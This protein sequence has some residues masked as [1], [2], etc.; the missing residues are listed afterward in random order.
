LGWGQ[1]CRR[2][3]LGQG[4][5]A[6]GASA[7]AAGG[8]SWVVGGG[9]LGCAVGRRSTCGIGVGSPSAVGQPSTKNESGN[10]IRT[11]KIIVNL[12][13]IQLRLKRGLWSIIRARRG[14]ISEADE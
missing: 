7:G 9:S 3:E 8:R 2:E 6:G 1:G 5:P 12:L 11:Q 10:G 4:R 13:M 14:L